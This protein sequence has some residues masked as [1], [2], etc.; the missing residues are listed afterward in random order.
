MELVTWRP[1]E[2][3]S[4]NGFQKRLH[5]CLSPSEPKSSFVGIVF[6]LSFLL[7]QDLSLQSDQGLLIVDSKGTSSS[8][9]RVP[10][11]LLY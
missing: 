2:L 10:I 7:K 1:A 9:A 3:L 4:L 5:K 11:S 8:D 6:H